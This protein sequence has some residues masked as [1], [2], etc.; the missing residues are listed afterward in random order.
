MLASMVPGVGGPVITRQAIPPPQGKRCEAPSGIRSR[1]ANG[2]GNR[3]TVIIFD[4]VPAAWPQGQ[5]AGRM[6]KCHGSGRDNLA[7]LGARHKATAGTL[8]L[9]L[10]QPGNIGQKAVAALLNPP[11]T[12]AQQR[13]FR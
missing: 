6:I 7:I 9:I 3:R 5:E 8:R 4:L 13:T 2:I 11:F 10:R 12:H 1:A